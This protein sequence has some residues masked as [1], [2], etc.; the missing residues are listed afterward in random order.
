MKWFK[1]RQ[2]KKNDAAAQESKNELREFIYL[3]EVSVTSLLSARDGAIPKEFKDSTG[4]VTKADV[5]GQAE[6]GVAPFKA[7]VNSKFESTRSAN[8]EVVSK[9]T[10]QTLV[11]RLF[12]I[13]RDRLVL[14]TNLPA[15]SRPSRADAQR[16]LLGELTPAEKYWVVAAADLDRGQLAEI[17]VELETDPVFQLSTILSTVKELTEESEDL[18]AQFGEK[19]MLE[20]LFSINNVIEK[21]MVGLIPLKCRVVDY[22]VVGTGHGRKV[23]HRCTFDD[24]DTELGFTATPLYLVGDTQ[25]DLYWKDIRRV[26]FT[27]SRFRVLCRLNGRGVSDRWNPLKLADALSRVDPLLS[28]KLS[29]FGVMAVGAFSGT[30]TIGTRVEESRTGALYEYG[31]LVAEALGFSLDPEAVAELGIL[32]LENQNVFKSAITA[33]IAFNPIKEYVELRAGNAL[34][35]DEHARLRQV[36]SRKNG[37]LID[38]TSANPNTFDGFLSSQP[39]PDENL[40][41]AEIIAI[42]W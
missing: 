34:T 14:R 4:S 42:Y 15:S 37:L 1:Q 39:R 22:V 19:E 9:A 18:R 29:Q 12:E 13:E 24:L 35:S 33:S 27:Q 26:L 36:A 32:A 41:E 11:N 6:A 25:K 5:A 20:G 10:V 2:E 8:S 40:I 30:A 38:G 3:D 16:I 17:E 28:E 31:E 23:V 7:R 21:M